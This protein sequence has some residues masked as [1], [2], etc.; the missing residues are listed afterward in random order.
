MA[1]V[2]LAFTEGLQWDEIYDAVEVFSG[3][4]VLSYALLAMGYAAAS[5]DIVNWNPWIQNRISEGR[6][7]L[8][9]GNPLDLVE[10]SGF[11]LLLSTIL[12]SKPDAVFAFGVVCSTWVAVSRGS[13]HRHYF[14][15]LGDPNSPSCNKANL[16]VA[17][18]CLALLL[19]IARGSTF[20]IE[21]PNSSLLY[22]HPRFNALMRLTTVFKQS[23]WMSGWGGK[24][25]KRT[26]LWSNSSA[27]RVF[28]TK[29]KH[30]VKRGK[31]LTDKYRDSSGKVRYKGNKNLRS[32][33]QYPLR[34]GVRFG[35]AMR[36]FHKEKATPKYPVDVRVAHLYINKAFDF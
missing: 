28:K 7:P 11:A 34:F 33:Q 15:P 5:L 8:C 26:V 10:P 1:V 21:Q 23:F 29:P 24:T 16:L 20:V 13:T 3:K 2:L 12:R 18:T 14:L 36:Y 27:V 35:R 32:S 30:R 31:S 19:I 25:P 9:K 17:R 4:G 22:R 6:K